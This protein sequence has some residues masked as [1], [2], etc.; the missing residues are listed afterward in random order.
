MQKKQCVRDIMSTRLCTCTPT[1]N[2]KNAARLMSTYDIG[3]VAVC[4][5]DGMCTGILTDRDLVVRCHAKDGDLYKMTVGELMSEAP[6]KISPDTRI[7]DA[8]RIM[9]KRQV[10]RLPVEDHGKLVGMISIGDI[11]RQCACDAEIGSCEC[12]IAEKE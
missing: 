9:G 8:I 4:N 6:E 12:A 1:E 10:R 5:K 7:S 3:C 2:A 11:A